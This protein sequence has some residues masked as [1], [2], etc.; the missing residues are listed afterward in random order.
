MRYFPE[1]NFNNATLNVLLIL[2][3]IVPSTLVFADP[4][5]TIPVDHSIDGD[6]AG[7]ASNIER[8]VSK[9]NRML[10]LTNAERLARGFKLP[11]PKGLV[12]GRGQFFHVSLEAPLVSSLLRA[13]LAPRSPVA[14][15]TKTGTGNNNHFGVSDIGSALTLHFTVDPTAART[16]QLDISAASSYAGSWPLMGGIDGVVNDSDNL[17]SGSSN[18]AYIQGTTQ[19]PPN[20]PPASVSNSYPSAEDSES[21]IWIYDAST[22]AITAQWIN[23][24]SLLPA[25]AFVAFASAA[26]PTTSIAYVSG[27]DA[28]ITGDSNAFLSAFA[29]FSIVASVLL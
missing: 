17:S 14:P 19:T 24:D 16:S 6:L 10:P 28:L 20:S 8:A 9:L 15:V 27:S 3:T 13:A 2:T 25:F 11:P 21:A 12:S 23:T 18:F 4:T 26:L 7:A 5:H 1:S 22:N 29:T